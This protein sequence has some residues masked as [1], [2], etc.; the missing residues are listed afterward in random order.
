MPT[1]LPGG[2]GAASFDFDQ[3]GSLNTKS[4]R[5]AI[6]DQEFAWVQNFMPIGPGNLRTTYAEGANISRPSTSALVIYMYPFNFGSNQFMAVF[7][8]DGTAYQVSLPGGVI[9]NIS[10][11]ADTF[12]NPSVSPTPPQCVQ[13]EAKYLIIATTAQASG[14]GYYIWDGS[15]LYNAGG[16]SPDVT[17]TNSGSGYTTTAH[18][19]VFGGSGTAGNV[20][21]NIENGAVTSVY[22]DSGGGSGFLPTDKIQAFAA[23]GNG[24]QQA[25][26]TVTLSSTSQGIGQVDILN[27]GT[28]YTTASIVSLTGGGGTGAQL[29]I[30]G[31]F[32][33]TITQISVVNPGNGYTSPPTISA[34]VGSGLSAVAILRG[35]QISGFSS[36]TNG[37]GYTSTPQVVIS[38]PDSDALPTVQATAYAT[39][40]SG[41][42]TAITIENPGLGY[43]TTP[44]VTLIGGNNCANIEINLMPFGV[45]GTCLET[46]Q[47]SIWVGNGTNITFTAPGTTAN[48][49][50]SAGG[51]AFSSTDNFLRQQIV[52]LRQS[53]G[54]LY[55]FADSSINVISNVQTTVSGAISTT[56]FNNSNVDPQIGCSWRD[57]VVAFGRALVF[58]NPNGVYALYGGAAQKVSQALDGLF[59]QSAFVNPTPSAAV[60]TIFNI[61][62]YLFNFHTFNPILNT[63]Q[64]MMAAWDGQKWFTLSGLNTQEFIATQEMGSL[65]TAWGTDFTNIF[66]LFQLPST[67]LS[68]TLQTKLRSSPTHLNTKQFNAVYYTA[69]NN[70]GVTST[71]QISVDNEKG[72]GSLETTP[73]LANSGITAAAFSPYNA[74]TFTTSSYGRYMGMSLETTAEDVSLILLSILYNGEYAPYAP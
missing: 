70:A 74:P 49:A 34:S 64:T 14:N 24:E 12:Y 72:N 48:F 57:T 51:G 46:Y 47:D 37:S 30:T 22:F 33:G 21:G 56:T 25:A 16:C 36:I 41:G 11:T 43:V 15:F 58:A 19:G 7:L 53:N 13:W 35:G 67:S 3:F 17:I 44:T 55:Y 28:G 9:T 42:V 4:S 65:L 10:T 18:F 1:P 68:K 59:N 71:L 62:V 63:F 2:E 20:Y 66:P 23:S 73:N 50:T 39:I 27:G 8:S 6:Q 54:F 61:P 26:Y 60:A 32:N 31:L 45:Q 29:V 52:A 38:A 40:T 5:L 69:I